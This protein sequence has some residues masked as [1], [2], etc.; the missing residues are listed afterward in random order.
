MSGLTQWGEMHKQCNRLKLADMVAKP[1]QRLTKY[2]L[3]LKSILKKTDDTSA[4]DVLN[5][6]VRSGE[7]C[8]APPLLDNVVHW[9]FST[10]LKNTEFV[11]CFAGIR[12][13]LELEIVLIQ[14]IRYLM[15]VVNNLL[16]LNCQKIV[17]NA[18]VSFLD[19]R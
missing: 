5:S 14:L 10:S 4:R 12:T 3:L 15:I 8:S 17:K 9:R 2:P 19:S 7:R 18:K 6:M 11:I 1:H 13:M 16:I